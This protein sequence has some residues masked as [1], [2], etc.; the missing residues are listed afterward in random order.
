MRVHCT[1]AADF[2]QARAKGILGG[3]FVLPVRSECSGAAELGQQRFAAIAIE[4][5]LGESA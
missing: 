4:Q 2:Q 1:A 3:M 5:P